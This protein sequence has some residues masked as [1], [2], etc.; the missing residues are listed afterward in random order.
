M[1]GADQAGLSAGNYQDTAEMEKLRQYTAIL[2]G[3]SAPFAIQNSKTVEKTGG[4]G[5]TIGT[6]ASLG[7]AIAAPF[8]GGASLLGGA[9]AIGGFSPDAANA[10]TKVP[11]PISWLGG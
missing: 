7:S 8:T 6:L 2:S 1:F 11:N 5:S 4:L 9:G 10:L 3:L